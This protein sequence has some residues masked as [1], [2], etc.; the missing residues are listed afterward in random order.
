MKRVFNTA[1]EVTHLWANQV[2]ADARCRNAKFDG[3]QFYS[4]STVIADIH[5]NVRGEELVLIC[6]YNYSSTTSNHK[7][8][9]ASAANH[10]DVL[11]VD[12]VSPDAR[13]HDSNYLGFMTEHAKLID[14]A[15]RARVNKGYLLQ[16]ANSLLRS[17]T[18]YARLVRTMHIK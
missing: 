18:D 1:S 11:Y 3:T 15:S 8:D 7:R 5:T 6:N 10:K 14:Q 13:G 9:V 12:L 2:Q 17:M 16:Q 4:Y